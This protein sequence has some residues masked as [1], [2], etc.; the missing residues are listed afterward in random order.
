MYTDK[1]NLPLSI[2]VWLATDAYDHN[3]DPMTIS[4]TSLLK[5]IKSIVMAMRSSVSTEVDISDLIPSKLG[6]AVHEAVEKAWVTNYV[7]ALTD[8]GYPPG[9][10]KSVCI[11]PEVPTEG[12]DVYLEQRT[13]KQHGNWSVSGQFDLVMDGKLE[14][15]KSTGVFT[16]M[17]QSNKDKFIQQGSIY[18]WL[19][20]DIITNDL[21]TILYVFTDWSAIRAKTDKNYPPNRILA[22]D[23]PLMSL[24]QTEKFIGNKLKEIESNALVDESELPKCTPEE[25]WERPAVFKYYKNPLKRAKSTKNFNNVYE[26]YQR[27]QDDGNVGEVVIIQGE[28]VYC[29]YCNARD[30]CSDATRFITEGRLVL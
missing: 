12:I 4:A 17:K 6:T 9:M 19:N 5:P 29:R 1:S 27:Q 11:N 8:L 24:D 7:Q 15:I 18:R 21:M 28:V 26:A 22:Q 20:Q 14:D 13:S 3:S 10:V 16:W 30:A 2:A 23:Y 25:L